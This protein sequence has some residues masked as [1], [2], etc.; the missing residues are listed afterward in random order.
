MNLTN[1]IALISGGASGMGM[2][3]AEKLSQLGA[4]I[5]VWDKEI[6]RKAFLLPAM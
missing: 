4:K 2:A 5:V 3:C 6:Q 1:K